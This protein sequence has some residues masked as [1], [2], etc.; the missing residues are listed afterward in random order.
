MLAFS[1]RRSVHRT[2]C[3]TLAAW[4]FALLAGIANACVPHDRATGHGGPAQAVEADPAQAEC[5]A[6]WEAGAL[7]FA[8]Q[9]GRDSNPVYPA[10]VATVGRGLNLEAVTVIT[11]QIGE[12]VVARGPP[13]AIRYLRLRL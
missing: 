6:A 4:T 5:D 9:E 11:P 7:V 13:G 12:G 10:A 8:E 2:V 3:M 1:P